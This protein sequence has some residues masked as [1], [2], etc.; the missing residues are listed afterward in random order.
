MTLIICDIDNTLLISNDLIHLKDPISGKV[1]R[2]VTTK[3]FSH[4]FFEDLIPDY[5]EFESV[6]NIKLFKDCEPAPGLLYLKELLDQI[7]QGVELGVLT[8]RANEGAIYDEMRKFFEVHSLSH[9][10]F[11]RKNA[12]AVGDEDYHYLKTVAERKLSVIQG[13]I[14]NGEYEKIIF[15]DD[16]SKNL[17]AI[18]TWMKEANV[19][20]SKVEC[21]LC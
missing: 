8:A 16:D 7:D 4:G 3:E 5:S 2:K 14:S 17:I 10:R 6:D 12:F 9:I 1:V 15:L 18:K 21:V 20:S 11:Q 19:K 13:L